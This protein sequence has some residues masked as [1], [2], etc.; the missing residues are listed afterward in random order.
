MI[1]SEKP[2]TIYKPSDIYK[3]ID[4]NIS[5]KEIEAVGPEIL[6]FKQILVILLDCIGKKK[7]L[8]SM[9]F[10]ISKILQVKLIL[11]G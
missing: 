7:P 10:F 1:K 2:F 6:T 5:G 3:V 8:I 9:P 4:E 11:V